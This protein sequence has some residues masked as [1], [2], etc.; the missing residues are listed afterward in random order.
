MDTYM[1]SKFMEGGMIWNVMKLATKS[2]T[3]VMQ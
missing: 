1:L 2:N 3:S